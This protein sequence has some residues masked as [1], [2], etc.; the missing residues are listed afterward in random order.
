VQAFIDLFSAGVGLQNDIRSSEFVKAKKNT[1]ED[2][3]MS[4]TIRSVGVS[5]SSFMRMMSSRYAT[6]NRLDPGRWLF[7]VVADNN[8]KK[9]Y[10]KRS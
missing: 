2:R 5:C 9:R 10:R 8:M 7:D 4:S 6:Y 3:R 1:L